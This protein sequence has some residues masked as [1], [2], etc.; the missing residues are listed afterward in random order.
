MRVHDKVQRTLN[1]TKTDVIVFDDKKN[2]SVEMSF[3]FNN[4]LKDIQ[5]MKEVAGLGYIPQKVLSLSYDKQY[6][7]MSLETFC[8]YAHVVDKF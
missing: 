2:K 3:I 5:V 4:K 7:E 1:I 8:K 6:L